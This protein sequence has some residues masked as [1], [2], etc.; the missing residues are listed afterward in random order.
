MY[1]NK[2]T[3]WLNSR[4]EP[5]LT[6]MSRQVLKNITTNT[7]S[8]LAEA[9]QIAT[10]DVRGPEELGGLTLKGQSNQISKVHAIG[11]IG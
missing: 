3:L 8:S 2:G 4:Q 10:E 5:P 6:Q 7:I 9:P 11:W 1:C